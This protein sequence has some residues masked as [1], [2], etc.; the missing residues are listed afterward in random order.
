MLLGFVIVLESNTED[1][2]G[3]FCYTTAISSD[4]S[5]DSV[6]LQQLNNVTVLQS[7]KNLT[8]NVIALQCQNNS[9][10]ETTDLQSQ[11]CFTRNVNTLRDKHGTETV[12]LFV[13]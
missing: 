1:T 8:E 13:L 3:L 12:A 9:S 11:N 6:K 2:S 10:T 4:Q 7:Q 5:C